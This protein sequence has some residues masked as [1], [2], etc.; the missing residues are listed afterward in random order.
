[1]LDVELGAEPV[2]VVVAGGS[3]ATQAEQPV[4]EL[5]AVVRQHPGDLHRRRALQIAQKPADVGSRPGR[6]DA[7]EHPA[8]SA[9]NRH[10]E[11][12]AD[13]GRRCGRVRRPNAPLL[14]GHPGQVFDVNM[15]VAGFVGLEG[16]VRGLRRLRLQ[17]PKVAPWRCRQRSS[18]ERE[19]LGFKNSR[20]TERRSSSGSSS[21]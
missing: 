11:V 6:V 14:I 20:T 3:T 4:G 7:H 16:L 5:L 2:E 1:M 19:T 9:I 12:R 10:E 21:A 15:Q 17:I 8:C 13:R 18:P